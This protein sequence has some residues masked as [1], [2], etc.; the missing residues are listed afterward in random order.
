M[1]DE[2]I[3][4]RFEDQDK[5]LKLYVDMKI[6][7]LKRMIAPWPWIKKHPFWSILIFIAMISAGIWVSHRI[8]L[9]Q[10]IE[11]TTGVIINGDDSH[12]V[13]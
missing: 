5:S 6:R 7:A 11:A 12:D 8:S 4:R 1:R 10:V 2:E 9:R 3:N 13:E